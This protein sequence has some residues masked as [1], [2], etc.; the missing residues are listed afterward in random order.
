MSRTSNKDFQNLLLPKRQTAAE[1][2]SLIK[3]KLMVLY[4]LSGNSKG[5]LT[6]F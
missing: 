5:P 6:V 4:K 1:H 3:C 2:G